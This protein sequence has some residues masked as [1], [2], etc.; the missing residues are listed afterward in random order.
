M[1]ST[2]RR[3]NNLI[4]ELRLSPRDFKTRVAKDQRTL[5]I[6]YET[7]ELH[8]ARRLQEVF[9]GAI[10]ADAFIEW[11]LVHEAEAFA[12]ALMTLTP[13]GAERNVLNSCLHAV[14]NGRPRQHAHQ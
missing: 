11:R 10:L 7:G 14:R 9:G 13:Q 5:V 4:H 1:N 6:A 2:L 8:V 12:N 3:L